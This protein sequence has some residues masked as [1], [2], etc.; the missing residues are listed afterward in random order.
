MPCGL[1]VPQHG[2]LPQQALHFLAGTQPPASIRVAKTAAVE[3]ITVTT[4]SHTAGVKQPQLSLLH[5]EIRLRRSQTARSWFVV[6]RGRELMA[7]EREGA[8]VCDGAKG[9]YNIIHLTAF[10]LL[11]A[12]ATRAC[13]RSELQG[14]GRSS[15]TRPCLHESTASLLHCCLFTASQGSPCVRHRRFAL[16]CASSCIS[17]FVA[18]RSGM[19]PA[20]TGACQSPV[21]QNLPPVADVCQLLVQQHQPPGGSCEL[22]HLVAAFHHTTSSSRCTAST[23]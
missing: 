21:A 8:C 14:G 9:K 4:G 6:V 23:R 12:A 16:G 11:D 17:Y 15:H 10:L 5:S 18:R 2:L 19:P 20:V 1:L 13:T 3:M 7:K 22:T